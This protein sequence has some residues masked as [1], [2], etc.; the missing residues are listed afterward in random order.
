MAIEL[1]ER[2]LTAECQKPIKVYYR[3][4]VVGHYEADLIVNEQIIVELK[5]VRQLIESH[6]VQLVNYLVATR[7]PVGL[8]INFGAGGV[9]VRRKVRQLSKVRN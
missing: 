8:L 5:S 3:G 4:R 1:S 6:E 9:E 7:K 2:E